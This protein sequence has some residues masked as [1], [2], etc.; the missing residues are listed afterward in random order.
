M[1]KKRIQNIE[2]ILE[3]PLPPST[4]LVFFFFLLGNLSELVL[5]VSFLVD[6]QNFKMATILASANLKFF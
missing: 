4:F 5:N 3:R 2:V 6:R 1:E